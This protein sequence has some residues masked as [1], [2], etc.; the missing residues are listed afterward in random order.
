MS[1]ADRERE[2]VRAIPSGG[3]GGGE[4]MSATDGELMHIVQILSMMES[5]LSVKRQ[6]FGKYMSNKLGVVWD[7]YISILEIGKETELLGELRIEVR[8]VESAEWDRN[9]WAFSALYC[10][11]YCMV[12]VFFIVLMGNRYVESGIYDDIIELTNTWSTAPWEWWK[13][14]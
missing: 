8:V 11:I 12:Y 10:C 9:C 3:G 13:W 6:W 5:Y 14:E 2:R 1:T 7:C 4:G